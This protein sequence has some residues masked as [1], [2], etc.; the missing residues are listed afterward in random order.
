ME[1]AT[2]KNERW[3]ILRSWRPYGLILVVGFLL[4]SRSLLFDFTYFDDSTLILDNFSF[5]QRF[6][7]IGAIFATDVFLSNARFY[8]RPLLNL[9]FMLEAQIA[10][11]LPFFYH[12]S[13]I[14]IHVLAAGLLF[15]L[16]DR[17]SRRRPL[18]LILSLIFLVH[19]VLVSA[20]V[21][22]PGRNDSLLAVFILAAFISF[23]HFLDRPRLISYL[24]FLFFF[25]AAL[26]TKESAVALPLLM[27][28]YAGLIKPGNLLRSDKYLL[29]L[30]TG[31]TGFIWF[32]MRQLAL[33]GHPLNYWEAITTLAKNWPALILDLGKLIFPFNLSVLPVLADSN[34]VYGFLALAVFIAAIYYLSFNS[35]RRAAF[36]WLWFFLFLAP[37]FIYFSRQ[38]DFLEHRLY[39]PFIGFLIFLSEA[40]ILTD[41]NWLRRLVR[42][43]VCLILLFLAVLNLRQGAYFSDR[44]TFWNR[45]VLDSPHSALA[46]RNLGVMLYF[47]GDLEAAIRH[48]RQALE[49]NPQEVMVHNNLGVIYLARKEYPQAEKEFKQE[50]QFNPNYDKA[51]FNLG[52]LAYR[53]GRFFEARDFFAATLRANPNYSEAQ[54]RLLILNDRLR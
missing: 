18:A 30:G 6:Q 12:L 43:G 10:G 42:G 25:L 50:L 34:L 44:L 31:V 36:G 52:D 1:E 37:S 7:N 3:S 5:L 47:E 51:L 32:L 48:Y 26:F 17:L 28:V 14:I 16:L 40:K 38:P 15:Y 45:A 39:L 27:L 13:N 41:L 24:A 29:L 21:W 53:R 35:K 22:I 2:Y 33:S 23:L 54:Q 19:P 20:V 9:T 8:Y 49:I 46:Q 4:Y 11:V